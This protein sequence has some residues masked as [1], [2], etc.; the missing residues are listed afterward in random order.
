MATK[1]TSQLFTIADSGAAVRDI[2]AT[3]TDI[4]FPRDS[5][6]VDITVLGQSAKT[7]A[8][9]LTSA[10][11][12]VSGIWDATTDGYLAGILGF[13]TAS[14]FVYAPAG[15]TSGYTKYTGSAY[16]MN[17]E[18]GSPVAGVVTYT[19]NFQVTGTITKTTY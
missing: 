19:A 1:G 13:A 15:S 7:F 8:P 14:A 3:I 5:D 12:T 11:F 6:M 9:T 17:Y 10:K 4:K 2:S 16:L 18:Q